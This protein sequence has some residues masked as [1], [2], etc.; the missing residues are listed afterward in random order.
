MVLGAVLGSAGCGLWETTEI[1]SEEA[2]EQLMTAV[3]AVQSATGEEW[4]VT[5]EPGILGCSR[6]HGQWTTS[7]SGAPTADR[8]A[9]YES[10]REALE[11]AGFTT[12]V[13]G[14]DTTTPVLSAQTPGGFGVDFSQPVEGGPVGFNASS[15]CFRE[16]E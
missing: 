7:W 3:E 16:E 2:R 9:A 15:D 14:E 8:N 5:V 13:N 1:N 4:V 11:R 12:Y 10:V 6:T